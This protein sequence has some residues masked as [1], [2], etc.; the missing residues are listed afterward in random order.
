MNC[1]FSILN[2]HVRRYQELCKCWAVDPTARPSFSKLKSFF[3]EILDNS[4]VKI[5]TTPEIHNPSFQVQPSLSYVAVGDL[6]YI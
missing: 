5:H 6:N 3:A 1:K 2:L 4:S